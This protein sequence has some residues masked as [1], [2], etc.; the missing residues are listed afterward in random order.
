MIIA[1]I[2][3]S[4]K[5]SNYTYRTITETQMEEEVNGNEIRLKS[6]ADMTTLLHIRKDSSNSYQFRTVYEKFNVDVDAGELKKNFSSNNAAQSLDPQERIFGA[7]NNA[8]LTARVAPDGKVISVEGLEKIRSDMYQLAKG[9]A[10][11][12]Q[13]IKTS[14]LN[15]ANESNWKQSLEQITKVFPDKAVKVG[16]QWMVNSNNVSDLGIE[17]P[18]TYSF[19]TVRNGVGTVLVKGKVDIEKKEVQMQGYRVLLSLKG[20]QTGTIKVDL[21]TGM[22]N[23]STSQFKATGTVTTLGQE[24][25]LTLITTNQTTGKM[26]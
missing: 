1:P 17:V 14:L 25:P 26:R 15:F 11:A 8:E 20:E 23:H 9:D 18:L 13:L 16:D 3:T 12:I 10:N 7:F 5:E 22:V 4:K 24:I 19:T 6:K 21:L 2:Q